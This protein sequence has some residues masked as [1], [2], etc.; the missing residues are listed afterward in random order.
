MRILD[1]S[2]FPAW[3]AEPDAGRAAYDR[4]HIPGAQ[5]FDIDVIADSSSDLP[6]MMP[7][8]E[9]FTASVEEMGIGGDTHVVVYDCNNFFAS[10]RVWWMFRTMGH[11]NV[12]VLNGGLQAWLESGGETE[13]GATAPEAAAHFTAA[14]K[15]EL[16]VSA[17]QVADT[18]TMKRPPVLDARPADR[19]AGRKPEPRRELK[20][21]HIPGS[22]NVP[23]SELVREDGRLLDKVHLDGIVRP[24]ASSPAIASCGSGVS[25]AIIALALAELGNWEVAIYDGSWSEWG[26]GEKNPV[27]VWKT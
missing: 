12:S 15:P 26:R 25:A 21:G 13:S 24:Y 19:F 14:P 2:W 1:G 6:H 11:E 16:V 23:A 17:D 18:L 27:E 22:M 7:G 20:P 10:A 3:V 4:R 9:I 5:F 8:P